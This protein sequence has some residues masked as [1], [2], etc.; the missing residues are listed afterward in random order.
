[1]NKKKAI[2]IA[3]ASAIAATGFVAAAPTQTD[4]AVNVKG[5]VARAKTVMYDAM[6]AYSKPWLATDELV[7]RTVAY[8]AYKKGEAQY[9]YAVN[10]VKK[11]APAKERTGILTELANVRTKY[12]LGRS[13]NYIKSWNALELVVE[14]AA[15]KLVNNVEKATSV[16]AINAAKAELKKV[17]DG[18][19]GE[20]SKVVESSIKAHV[21][22]EAKNAYDDA[23][24]IADESI[25]ELQ[26]GLKVKEVSAS[27]DKAINEGETLTLP[28]TVEV[29]LVNG[30][31]AQ[32]AVKWDTSK[33]DTK[34]A[35][36]YEAKGD[37]DDT[38]LEATVK[39]EVKS[40]A[41]QVTDVSAI[42]SKTVKVTGTFL[43][44]LKAENFSL[45]GNKVTA[46]TVNAET[47]EGTL[48]FES[49]VPSGKEQVLKL[50]EKVEG[51]ADKVIEF[52]FTYTLAIEAIS[53]NAL[54]VDNDT[55]NQS[56]TFK[57]NKDVSDADLAYV[58]AAGY[59][60]EFQATSAVFANGNSNS[61]TGVLASSDLPEKFAYKVVISDMDGK[62]VAESNLTEVKVVDKSN[63]IKSIDSFKLVKGD[64]ELSS[65]T[66]VAS[67]E[68]VQIK[69]VV[70]D[71]ADGT[72]NTDI[73]GLVEYS[74]SNKN[75]AIVDSMGV[76]L[77]VA[78]GT[79][80]I[81]I[82]SGE[83]T[84]TFTL[85]IASKA[86][87]V[88]N[89]T[90]STSSVRLVEA[91]SNATVGVVVKDQYGE[92]VDSFNLANLSYEASTVSVDGEAKPIVAVVGGTTDEKGKASLTLSPKVAGT[93]TVKIKSGDTVLKTIT[94]SVSKEIAV[95][96]RKFELADSAKDTTLDLFTEK[97]DATVMF[98]YNQYNASG[99]LLGAE[100]N[101]TEAD[102][103]GT[104]KVSSS[105][106]AAA[107]VG[108]TAD[109]TITVTGVNNGSTNIIVKEGSVERARVTVNVTDSTPTLKTITLKEVNKVTRAGAVE[110]DD[111]L[112]L[113]PSEGVNID[114]A[115]QNL[116]LTTSSTNVVRLDEATG[117]LYLDN[118]AGTGSMVGTFE[119]DKETPIGTIGIT[120]NL[121]GAPVGTTYTV[122]AGS[123]G[124]L[125]YS[126]KD[127]SGKVV[128]TQVI[129]V[130]VPVTTP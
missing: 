63:V 58:K 117:K 118:P 51:E 27:A 83:A 59:T 64:L 70:G 74:S 57:L 87:E 28:E 121:A 67:E 17:Y 65:N 53:A 14:P 113:K 85:T 91:G 115:V 66:V 6:Y 19:Q 29:T 127:S 18:Q 130:E 94:V 122:A 114:R 24:V 73:T 52:K 46:F 34:K 22:S 32:K 82:K 15:A 100:D 102:G 112:S 16:E 79:T 54:I 48:T 39:V 5:E 90:L 106:P 120:E 26:K 4:A 43:D 31:K 50:T 103:D 110:A 119:Q 23:I 86:R 81:T 84:K 128:A 7:D 95:A 56:L 71:K 93:G 13:L 108:V 124:T 69:G 101:I 107:S 44:K 104:Y 97:D 78:P 60:V 72:N 62:K 21:K 35:G 111:V 40:V 33:V 10:Y 68:G 11:Y 96:N 116:T 49:V 89:L 37:I 38:D 75:V 42:N 30:Q 36:K 1:M 126:I 123:K 125:V 25:A 88:S 9:K 41:P 8:A 20:L 92:L 47:G 80:T 2:K 105:N 109:G 99:Y 129:E 77:P 55:A 3:T 61:D 98:K 12:L 76:I 45:E